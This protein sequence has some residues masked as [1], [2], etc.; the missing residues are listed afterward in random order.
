M[1]DKYTPDNEKRFTLRMDLELF[2]KISQLAK[3]N[4]RSTAKEIEVAV[5]M[6]VDYLDD[7]LNEM[8]NDASN[9]H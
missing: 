9:N 5:E 7:A 8:L 4:R 6:Y 3:I 2:E 1:S